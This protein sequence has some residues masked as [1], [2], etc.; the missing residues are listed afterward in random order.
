ML[1]RKLF[2]SV[3]LSTDL[4]ACFVAAE[5]GAWYTCTDID[6]FNI[7]VLILGRGVKYVEP[8]LIGQ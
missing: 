1:D 3:K 5:V 2:S 7:G 6:R 8:S 4:H